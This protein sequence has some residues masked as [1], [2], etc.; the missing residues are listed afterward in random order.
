[1]PPPNCNNETEDA[2]K[3]RREFIFFGFKTDAQSMILTLQSIAIIALF[4]WCISIASS[5]RRDAKESVEEANRRADAQVQM[6]L[7]ILRPDIAEMKQKVNTS[8]E[9]IDT[10]VNAIQEITKQKGGSK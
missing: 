8:S 3:S 6:V 9:R 2:R 10:A 4:G 7:Q 1:M 5:T